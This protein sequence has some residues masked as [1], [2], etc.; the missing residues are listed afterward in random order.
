MHG[1]PGTGTFRT[2]TESRR[3]V[4]RIYFIGMPETTAGV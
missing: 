3:R 1:A 4:R 2:D